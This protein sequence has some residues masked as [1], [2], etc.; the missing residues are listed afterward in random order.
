MSSIEIYETIKEFSI[1]VNDIDE[2]V[3]AKICK[4]ICYDN[5]VKYFWFISHYYTPSEGALGPYRPS[6]NSGNSIDTVEKSLMLYIKE[7]TGIRVE[8]NKYY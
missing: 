2:M 7:F 8:K 3:K 4:F 5:E 6:N 1:Y